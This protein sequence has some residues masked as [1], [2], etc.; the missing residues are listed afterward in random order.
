VSLLFAAWMSEVGLITYRIVSKGRPVAAGGYKIPW[1]ADYVATFIVF[2]PLSL[3]G[4]LRGGWDR[5]AAL[6]GWGFVVAT[7]LN[8]V[9]PTEGVA[10]G[11]ASGTTPVTSPQS[12]T[13]YNPLTQ[14]LTGGA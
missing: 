14:A 7:V 8:L 13:P 3:L 12:P 2:G 4:E 10:A 1:P 9:D 6:A 11:K 5:V